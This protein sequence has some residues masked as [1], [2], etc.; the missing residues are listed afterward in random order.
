MSIFPSYP[1]ISIVIPTFN[2]VLLLQKAIESILA[3]T[4]THW[5]LIVVDDGSTDDTA[6]TICAIGDSRIHLLSLPHSGNI[7]LL[8]NAGAEAGSGEWIAFLDSDDEW[9]S[10]KLEVQLRLLMTQGKRWSYGGYELIDETSKTI[11][12]KVRRLPPISGWIIMPLLSTGVAVNM[13]SLM[14]ERKFFKEVGGFNTESK[15][16]LRED[17]EF[18]LRLALRAEALAVPRLLVRIR[19]H[20]ARTTNIFNDGHERTAYV[21]RHFI[22]LHPGGG[23]ER[24]ARK[25]MGYHL[26][27][28]AVNCMRMEKYSQAIQH[29]TRAF[30]NGDSLKHLLSAMRRGLIARYKK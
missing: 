14:I 30:A 20:K 16:I 19:E 11:P 1:F 22:N 13:G 3:Q 18:A 24:L 28:I 23:P 6:K 4:Y 12:G 5:E 10:D 25:R 8:R 26:A 15:L 9:V 27:E 2:R 29:F 21:Y 7:A 17:Y